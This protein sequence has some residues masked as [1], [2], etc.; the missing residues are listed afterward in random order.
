M[1]M[2]TPFR[3]IVA[4]TL[5]L[6]GSVATL[7]A[8]QDT[9]AL[10]NAH[11]IPASGDPIELG[12]VVIRDGL[13]AA[14][15]ADVAI[16]VDARVLD[17]AGKTVYPGFIDL[18][19]SAGLAIPPRPAR[20]G[21]GFGAARSDTGGFTGMDPHR[22]VAREI[23]PEHE[24]VE[25]LRNAGFTTVLTAPTSGLYRGQSAFVNL[26]GGEAAELVVASPVALHMA[27]DRQRGVYPST[28]MGV[29]AYQ[30]QTMLDARYWAA[31][32]TRYASNPEG[33]E[34]P[35]IDEE[36]EA[37][38]PYAM[39][40]G[41]VIFHADDAY[42]VRR[43][44]KLGRELELNYLIAGATEGWQIRDQL[45]T[46]NRP[47]IVSVNFGEPSDMTGY[48]Y[49]RTRDEE[50]PS[51]SSVAKLI[52]SNAAQLATAGVRFALTSGG[53]LSPADFMRNVKAAVN[54]GLSAE[55]A[56]HALTIEPARILGLDDR[57]GSIT[58]GKIANLVVTSEPLFSDSS[59]VEYV[60]IDGERFLPEPAAVNAGAGGGGR[61][62]PE[63][64]ARMR[65]TQAETPDSAETTDETDETDETEETEEAVE[66]AVMPQPPTASGV[67]A[68]TNAT[69]MTASHGTIE[70]ATVLVRN[71]KIA[72]VGT[73]VRVPNDAMVIDGTGKYV[74]PGFVDSHSHAAMEGG[75]NESTSNTTPQVCVCDEI[76]ADQMT[77]FRAL[78]GGTTTLH[79]LHGSANSI[80]GQDAVIKTRW[81]RPVED[82]QVEGAMRG[83]KFAL[84]ENPKRSNRPNIPGTERRAPSTRMGVHESIREAFEKARAYQE[85]WADYEQARRVRSAARRGQEPM[86]PRRDLY[87]EALSEILSGD[88]RI[89]SHGYRA[90]ELLGLIRIADEFGIK[91][92]TLQHVL[93]GYKIADEIAAHGAGAST[94]ADN[95]AYKLEAFDAIPHNAALMSDRDV[96]VSINSDSG[97][98]VRRLYQ[99]AAKAMHF[100]GVSEEEAL[101]MITLNPATDVGI[102]DKVG[103]VDVGKDADLAIFSGHPFHPQSRVEKTIIDG[104]VY[105][106]RDLV[107]TLEKLIEKEKKPVTTTTGEGGVR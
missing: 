77:I 61:R 41:L 24:S 71:G 55:R 105:F 87:L 107:P 101:R 35:V 38:I 93:E 70:G 3:I 5:A 37:L 31:Y 16:P 54:A 56:V 80:G 32:Q 20:T 65:M 67:L 57:L 28:L 99:E 43:A 29:M 42:A 11:I 25:R 4:A 62:G 84:G 74:T 96:R 64:R 9:W 6:V 10:T 58:T 88:I 7:T 34:R 92:A 72:E 69:V 30:R 85:E 39:G 63:M 73:D 76:V 22:I 91:I 94:F 83:I 98:R 60:F 53:E 52:Q 40:Q 21:R 90:D 68:I 66:P 81:G 18:V 104:I 100:G 82:L 15:G 13:I 1:V 79:L 50:L 49:F 47:L 23:D 36:T 86:P 95:W 97:E 78:A 106:D 44:M 19:T 14:V 103:S 12:T 26:R 33:M 48:N 51:D 102:D 2:K 75:I 89:H 46:A 8:Q 17:L 45:A 59:K 27:F